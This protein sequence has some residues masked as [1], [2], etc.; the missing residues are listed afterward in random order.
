MFDNESIDPIKTY[1]FNTLKR[2]GTTILYKVW[3]N[4]IWLRMVI[5]I[6]E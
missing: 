3:W 4:G 6:L 2:S 5:K 1:L